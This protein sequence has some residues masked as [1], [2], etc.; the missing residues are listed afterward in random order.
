MNPVI[1]PLAGSM[2]IW[3]WID[4]LL[5]TI[6]GIQLF[7]LSEQTELYFAWTIALPLTAAFLGASYLASLAL[8]YLSSRKQ[9]WAEARLAVFGVWVFTTI[10]TVI[11]LIH[12]GRF[13][14]TSP[15]LTARLAAW[16]W[17]AIYL[18]VP[19]ALLVLIVLQM[20]LPG[21]DPA[22][23][24]RLPSWYRLILGL[25]ALLLVLA[26]AALLAFPT[27]APWPWKLTPLTGA[28][29]GA[30]LVGVS[31]IATQA[32]WENDWSRVWNT[33]LSYGFLA[34]LQLLALARYREVVSWSS[35]SAGIYVFFL[36]SMLL[37]SIAGWL[38][39]RPHQSSQGEHLS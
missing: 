30:W 36:V 26:G 21:G 3:F 24:L 18:I 9:T 28:A 16:F 1:R 19:P 32:I 33:N 15:I 10:T 8:V 25:Q 14:L 2:R 20:R 7:I 31:V 17:L 38:A 39:A 6:A 29:V 22:R 5:V 12:L 37:L 35:P 13:H 4:C 11:T 27:A 34:L 23:R